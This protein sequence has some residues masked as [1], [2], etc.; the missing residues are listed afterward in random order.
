MQKKIDKKPSEKQSEGFSLKKP[1][2]DKDTIRHNELF[3]HNS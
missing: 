3:L 1:N 2:L